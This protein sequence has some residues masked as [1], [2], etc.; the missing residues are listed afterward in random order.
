VTPYYTD[1]QATIYHADAFDIL[2]RLEGVG[3]LVTD[4]PYSSGGAFR[5][6]RMTTALSKYASSD[7]SA[8]RGIGFTGDNRDQRAFLAWCSL[9]LTA[10]RGASVEG[11]TFAIFTDWRQL[12]TLTDAVQVAGY[13]WRGVG[14][15]SKKFGRPRAGGFSGACEF[16]AWGS[17]GALDAVPTYPAGVFECSAPPVRTR[18]HLTEKPEPVMAWALGNVAPGRLVLDPFMGS[19]STLIAARLR[20]CSAV[21]VE[22]DERYCEIVARRLSQELP[23]DPPT[24][25]SPGLW[26]RGAL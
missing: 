10:C 16:L 5:G 14:A 2:P 8:Q 1:G 21:G 25:P 4:P 17:H 20:G 11:A 13:V 24:M 15:W 26:G 6:D 3:A 7:S 12:P 23:F 9:W 19:G 22:I 18:A